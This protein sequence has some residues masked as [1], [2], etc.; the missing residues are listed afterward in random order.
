MAN[1]SYSMRRA[2]SVGTSENDTALASQLMSAIMRDLCV[3][4]YR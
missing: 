2:D 1:F 4:N 3:K